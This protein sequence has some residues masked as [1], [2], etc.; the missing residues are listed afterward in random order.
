MTLA[1]FFADGSCIVQPWFAIAISSLSP[2]RTCHDFGVDS[3]YRQDYIVFYFYASVAKG[4]SLQQSY[5][6]GKVINQQVFDRCKA[7]DR[8]RDKSCPIPRLVKTDKDD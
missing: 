6:V 3:G 8:A 1:L 5:F 4:S 7:K 2:F